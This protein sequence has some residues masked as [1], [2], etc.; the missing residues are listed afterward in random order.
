MKRKIRLT[1][2]GEEASENCKIPVKT[3]WENLIIGN[4]DYF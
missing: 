4:R 3:P 2:L 1:E